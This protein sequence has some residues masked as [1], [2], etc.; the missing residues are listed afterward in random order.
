MIKLIVS[1]LDGTLLDEPNSISKIN[2]DAIDYA[3]KRGARFGFAT[4]R[5]FISIRGIKALLNHE[6]LLILNN[7]ALVCEG[8]GTIVEEDFFPNQYLEVVIE[9]LGR[10][11]VPYMIFTMEG[12]FT[13]MDPDEVR[14]RFIERIGAIRSVEYAD[15]FRFDQSKPCNNLVRITDMKEFIRTKKILKVEGFH[16]QSEPVE[17]AKRDL[18]KYPELSHASTGI[19]NVEVTNIT[20]QKGLVLKKYIQKAGIAEDEVM[21]MGDSQNDLS[22]FEHFKYSFAPENSCAEIKEKAYCV[23]KSCMEHGVSDAIYRFI[24]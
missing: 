12:F 13:A 10:H 15:A 23:V 14:E 16:L 22:L 20:A 7:G 24:K 2:L 8:D 6:P 18:E 4:G 21:V 11:G 9:I 3:Y 5:D 1:D 17:A 19:N